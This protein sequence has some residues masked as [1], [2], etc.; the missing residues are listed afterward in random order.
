MNTDEEPILF[1]AQLFALTGVAPERQKV[2]C[3]GII[4]KDT[5]WNFEIKTG[6]VILLLGTKDEVPTGP[7]DQP[8]FIEDMNESELA[9]ALEVP[10]GLANLG[11]TCYM[12]ATVQC[13]KSCNELRE[14]LKNF[15]NELALDSMSSPQSLAAVMKITF[16]RM[17]KN[18]TVTPILLLQ[19]LHT[20]FP[21]F[22]QTG[23]NG[24]YRQQDANECWSEMLKMLQQKLPPVGGAAESGKNSF[25]EQYFGGTMDIEMKCKEATEE[26][27]TFSK[28]NFLQLSCF[29]SQDVKYMHSGLRSVS[30]LH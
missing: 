23:E 28:E 24:S 13:L 7:I 26:A 25:I 21:Q 8:K 27:S 6:S 19:T 5:E 11:N 14:A 16:E 9:T 12:N 18:T 15:N 1:K 4:L 3:K 22:A 20:A 10:A 17:E 29:I 2:M 30:R